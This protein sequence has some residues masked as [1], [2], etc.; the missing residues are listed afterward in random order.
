MRENARDRGRRLVSEGRL[1]V[2]RAD[3]TEIYA[4]C[5]GDSGEVHELGFRDDAG[6][7]C[8]CPARSRC[9]HLVALQLVTVAPGG[10]LD[11]RADS[12]GGAA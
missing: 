12:I 1:L 9:G 6:W 4:T 8:S 3:E 10:A 11:F 5:R 7:Y 2:C